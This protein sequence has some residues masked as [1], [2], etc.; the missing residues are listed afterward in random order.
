MT[1][2]TPAV[3]FES[4]AKGMLV[5]HAACAVV[6]I[7]A[8]T[9]HAWLL[10]RQLRGREVKPAQQRLHVAI[11]AIAYLATFVLGTLI[12]PAFRV[13]VR[14]AYFDTQ[15]PLATGAF[16]IKEHWLAVGLSLLFIQVPLSRRLTLDGEPSRAERHLFVANGLLLAAVVWLAM[17]TGFALTALM[18]V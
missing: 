12:Y 13:Y 14:A 11:L 7:G 5:L 17:V 6:T 2:M 15:V 18:P 3:I 16:E 10:V 8:A 9:H 4:I 1:V